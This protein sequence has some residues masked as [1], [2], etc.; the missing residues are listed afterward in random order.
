MRSVENRHSWDGLLIRR[1]RVRFPDRGPAAAKVKIHKI[2]YDP[3]GADYTSDNQLRAE[4]IVIRNTGNRRRQLRNWVVRDQD[5]HGFSF[6]RYRIPGR[7]YVK[8]HTGS[9]GTSAATSTGAWTI[10]YGTTMATEQP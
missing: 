10:S 3:P 2:R 9:G 6:P 4:Y 8:V 7:G 5:G 1:F